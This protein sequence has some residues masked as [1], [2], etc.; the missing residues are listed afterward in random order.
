MFGLMPAW[1]EVENSFVDGGGA[2]HGIFG[3]RRGV[4]NFAGRWVTFVCPAACLGKFCGAT[5]MNI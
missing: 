2:A 4:P 1:S 5:P 3:L